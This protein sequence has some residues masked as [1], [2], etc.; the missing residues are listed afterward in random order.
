[1]LGEPG[2]GGADYRNKYIVFS[3][4]SLANLMITFTAA[5]T[6]PAGS[7]LTLMSVGFD[8]FTRADNAEV[9]LSGS[10]TREAGLCTVDRQEKS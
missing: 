8:P 7:I 10:A 3:E 2:T 9:S 4:Q 1:M 5:G 6:M